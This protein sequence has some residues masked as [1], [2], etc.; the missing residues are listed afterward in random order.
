MTLEVPV[1]GTATRTGKG[2]VDMAPTGESTLPAVPGR[3]GRLRDFEGHTVSLDLADGSRIE[4]ATVVSSGR[5]AAASVWIDMDG[6]DVFLARTQIVGVADLT[7]ERA[8]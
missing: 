3:S 7:T 5:G 1:T 8:A 4:R 6:R 2:E